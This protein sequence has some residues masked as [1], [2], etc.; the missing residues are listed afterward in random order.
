MENGKLRS[1]PRAT[2]DWHVGDQVRV[3]NGQ[4]SQ[5]G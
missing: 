2:D 5:R 3:V 4:L 1:F